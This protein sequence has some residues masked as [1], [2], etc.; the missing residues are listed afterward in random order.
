[1]SIEFNFKKLHEVRNH[2]PVFP[3]LSSGTGIVRPFGD[4]PSKKNL[5]PSQKKI[6]VLFFFRGSRPDYRPDEIGT[7]PIF[8]ENEKVS[9]FPDFELKTSRKLWNRL[10]RIPYGSALKNDHHFYSNRPISI[11]FFYFS[12]VYVSLCF[13]KSALWSV[14]I[15]NFG[16][17][18]N[19]GKKCFAGKSENANSFDSAL[20][21]N[22]NFFS[23]C[24]IS[25]LIFESSFLY[26]S[27]F[28]IKRAVLSIN[29]CDFDDGQNLRKMLCGKKREPKFVR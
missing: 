18:Q 1:M 20:K 12:S 19:L 6:S 16:D 29:I 13:V 21:N 27:L 14:N 17:R 2:K 25:I 7:V 4:F 8:I 24:P 9:R 3:P 10:H 23:S 15:W 11:L 28:C 26:V 5:N 22:H